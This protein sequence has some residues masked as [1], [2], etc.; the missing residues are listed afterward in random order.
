MMHCVR[1]GEM[2]LPRTPFPR[3]DRSSFPRCSHLRL[4]RLSRID[5]LGELKHARLIFTYRMSARVSDLSRIDRLGELI[6]PPLVPARPC[7]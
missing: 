2:L 5:R 7:A 1:G 4:C 3:L 6:R